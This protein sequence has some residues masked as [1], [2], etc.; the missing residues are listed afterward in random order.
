MKRALINFISLFVFISPFSLT[1]CNKA[2]A[3]EVTTADIK[4][5]GG[6][7]SGTYNIGDNV[8]LIAT[9]PANKLFDYWSVNN[10]NVS[11]ENPYTFIVTK[12]AT[13]TACFKDDPNPPDPDDVTCQL[14]VVSDVHISEDDQNGKNHLK[15][16][17][18]YALN[19][20]I[21]AIIF[22]GDTVNLG[23]QIEYNALD[24][25]LTQ[26]YKTPKAEGLP[27]LI[28]NMGNHE[29]YPTLNCAH[30]ETKYEREYGYFKA[31]ADKW[32]ETIDNNVFMRDVNGVRCVLAF[33]SAERSYIQNGDTMY[34][35]SGDTVYLAA[36]GGYSQN[37][38]NKVKA[39]FDDIIQ[40]GYDKPIIFCTHHPLGQTYGSTLYGMNSTSEFAFRE[41]LKDYPMITHL[42]GHTHFSSLHERSISQN[43][44]TSI[45]I[46]T[47][48]YGKY[49]SEVDYDED[50]HF[51]M[52]ENITGKRYND[53]DPQAKSHHGET[54][55]GTLLSFNGTNMIVERV[56]LSTGDIYNHGS[57]TVPYGITK[58]NKNSKFQYKNDRRGEQ[59]SFD[60]NSEIGVTI[61]N[62]KL[63]S[64]SFKDV[65]QYWA[66]EGYIIE[67]KNDSNDILR[68]V[69]W[70]SLFWLG[71][72][73]KQIY[74]L[75]LSQMGGAIPVSNGYSVSI[76]GINF[77]GYFSNVLVK[78]IEA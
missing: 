8:T 51:L 71:A 54:N 78:T 76:R 17:L 61:N 47:H 42:S 57:W 7:G 44:Y 31:F 28:F 25:V 65:E 68:R 55:F 38:I 70:S 45:Q 73:E 49:V 15:N 10:K 67:I 27:K 69:L 21:D 60:G 75:P 64:L 34:N 32:G 56:Y 19:N 62:G 50:G 77:F 59:L 37:D 26:V 11:Q 48:T 2:N 33:P 46:G 52:Y 29:F 4:V 24:G 23:R 3:N 66:C 39:Q 22:D 41:M 6:T 13:Y 16:T 74:T 30:E 18:N 58:E 36:T 53:Y 40:S 72:K 1:A 35:H 5:I 43:D 63:T 9:V 14:L 20:G 12:T